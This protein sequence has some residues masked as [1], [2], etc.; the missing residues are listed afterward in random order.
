M[1]P[2]DRGPKGGSNGGGAGADSLTSNSGAFADWLIAGQNAGLLQHGP[3]ATNFAG[4]E[5]LNGGA[6]GNNFRVVGNG[7]ISGTISGGVGADALFGNN[8]NSTWAINAPNAGTL[9]DANGANAFTGIENV[10]GGTGNDAFTLSGAGSISG[11]ISGG[12]GAGVDTLTGKDL[13]STWTINAVNAGSLDD[14]SGVNV[15]T[16]IENLVGGTA[17]DTFVVLNTGMIGSIAGGGQTLADTLDLSLRTGLVAINTLGSATDVGIF[18]GIEAVIGNSGPD[19]TTTTLT[20]SNFSLTGANSGTADSIAYSGV[21]NLQGRDGANSFSG[22]M[23][24]VAGTIADGGNTSALDGVITS[25]GSQSYSQVTLTANTTTASTG[26]GDIT[27]AQVIAGG[28]FSLSVNTQ[29][30]GRIQDGASGLS[31]LSTDAG[32]TTELTGTISTSGDQTYGDAVS[33]DSLTLTSTGGGNITAANTL[34]DFAGTLSFST[35]GATQISDANG[36][37]LSGTTGSLTVAAGGAVTQTGTLTVNGTGSITATGSPITLDNA[38]NNFTGLLTLTGTVVKVTDSNALAVQLTTGETYIIANAG[39]STGDLRLSGTTG[40]LIAVTNGGV[41]EWGNLTT[42]NAILIAGRPAINGTTSLGG[43]TGPST[44]GNVLAENVTYSNL[45]DA[46]GAPTSAVPAN[47][48]ASLVVN[49]ELVLIANN[50]PRSTSGDFPSISAGTAILDINSLTPGDRVKLVLSGALR[51]LADT[52]TFRF[53]EG[54][55][56][57]GGVTTLNPDEVQVLIGGQSLTSTRDELAQRAARTAA[58]QSA[59]NS[60]SS[61]ARQSFGTDS[62]TQQIDMGFSGDVGVAATL[63]HSVPLEGEIIATPPC[64]AEARGGQECKK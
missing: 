29:G 32:G 31:S 22:G 33:G 62:V 64:V 40:N 7:N 60:A 18:S 44:T 15:F 13:D 4:I 1:S 58:Q 36:L 17:N 14:A 53:R 35:T 46:T 54:S 30:T 41:L 57:P 19:G 43:I 39:G 48:P 51:L 20:G 42:A 24:S 12:G 59:L 52:G 3:I 2:S 27:F 25:G 16:G 23:G 9:T 45:N 34:N 37:T 21:G 49:G 61:D 26:G 47:P 6:S 5:N 63:G 28:G 10:T 50:L 55:S 56:F 8:L 11:T 38:G